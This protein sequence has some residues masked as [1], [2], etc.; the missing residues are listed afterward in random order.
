L[1]KDGDE[2]VLKKRKVLVG[3]NFEKIFNTKKTKGRKRSPSVASQF[4][5]SSPVD[6][7]TKNAKRQTGAATKSKKQEK[8]P[9]HNGLFAKAKSNALKNKS[10]KIRSQVSVM[11]THQNL[12]SSNTTVTLDNIEKFRLESTLTKG[13]APPNKT[14]IIQS[15]QKGTF[16]VNIESLDSHSTRPYDL[17]NPID[18]A[19]L[20]SVKSR[21]SI[22]S[23][24]SLDNSHYD[25]ENGDQNEQEGEE[26]DTNKKKTGKNNNTAT[27]TKPNENTFLDSTIK[28]WHELTEGVRSKYFPEDRNGKYTTNTNNSTNNTTEESID[29]NGN[30]SSSVPLLVPNI[31]CLSRK[32]DIMNFLR[33]PVLEIHERPCLMGDMCESIALWHHYDTKAKVKWQRTDQRKT[34]GGLPS[35]AFVLREF[36]LPADIALVNKRCQEGLSM[37]E[38]MAQL[39]P[40]ACIICNRML[41]DL[42]SNAQKSGIERQ[43][44][45]PLQN[46]CNKFDEPGEYK[47]SRCMKGCGSEFSG[48]HKPIVCYDREH[49]LLGYYNVWSTDEYNNNNNSTQNNSSKKGEKKKENRMIRSISTF[50]K[51]EKDKYSD[52]NDD[53]QKKQSRRSGS[54]EDDDEDDD[55]EGDAEEERVIKNTL[56]TTSLKVYKVAGWI[57]HEDIIYQPGTDSPYVKSVVNIIDR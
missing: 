34:S 27:K 53:H 17:R 23:P 36:L 6:T 49:Y 21:L 42:L 24:N 52:G 1:E 12:D 33:A 51:F 29:S 10:S 3:M 39:Q 55:D 57:E 19:L 41:T 5:A 32:P 46:H 4:D 50:A 28:A 38:A 37:K 35:E 7:T 2:Q 48:I 45:L 15:Q 31:P 30:L 13:K 11:L 44:W 56:Q 43:Q 26:N 54:D 20:K 16:E 22:M 25:Q 18:K 8:Q 47:K 40:R 14:S 9:P